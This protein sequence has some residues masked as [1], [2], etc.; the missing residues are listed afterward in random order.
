MD[1]IK[2][3]VEAIEGLKRAIEKQTEALNSVIIS[4][5]KGPARVLV[6]TCGIVEVL[7]V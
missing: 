3:L 1:D 5:D 7:K 2:L 4:P 6:G